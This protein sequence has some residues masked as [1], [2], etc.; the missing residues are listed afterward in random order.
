[1]KRTRGAVLKM[2]VSCYSMR[3]G[4]SD[5]GTRTVRQCLKGKKKGP[6]LS[7]ESTSE[8]GIHNSRPGS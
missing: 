6:A 5:M 8:Q 2:G 3:D 1:M 4:V 7:S